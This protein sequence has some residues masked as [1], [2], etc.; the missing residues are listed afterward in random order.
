MVYTV[1]VQNQ[2][3][4]SKGVSFKRVKNED[5]P[6]KTEH[7]DAVLLYTK[8]PI[9]KVG[10]DIKVGASKLKHAFTDYPLRGFRG[11]KNAN[12]YEFLTMGTVPY[13]A[14]SATMIAVFNLAAKF[15]D[16]PSAVSASKL[17]K[18]MAIGV[19][20]YGVAKS[21]SKKL[22]ETPVKLRYG[23][24]PNLQ[25]KA[26][27]YE[28]PDGHNEKNLTKYEYHKV[29]E[30]VDFP[31]W[32]LLYDKPEFGEKRNAYFDKVA[33]RMHKKNLDYS[34]QKVKDGI[35]EK[36]VQTKLFTTL[37]SYLWAA[38]AVGVAMQ[39]PFEDL[40]LSSIKYMGARLK[41]AKNIGDESLKS[42]KIKEI[43]KEPFVDFGKRFVNSCKEFVNNDKKS[44]K[45]AGRAL[46]GVAAG[47]TLLGNFVTLIDFNKDKG[48]KKIATSP[49]IDKTKNKVV[50]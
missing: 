28:L 30:S 5:K 20:G 24:D 18:K 11:S 38:T 44:L 50:C 37:S 6:K 25:Y 48:S 10:T 33:K 29:F 27:I 17:G 26:R 40:S 1:G 43:I 13:L 9:K 34:D 23:I 19:A 2:N 8:N 39:K 41:N 21:L 4:I 14:G 7:E 47:V 45:Y 32:N 15:F 46:L 22:I 35:R 49:L 31:Y 3:I 12:F 36:M 42:Q 16:T